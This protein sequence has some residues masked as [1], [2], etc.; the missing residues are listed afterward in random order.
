MIRQ[1]V[2]ILKTSSQKMVSCKAVRLL[3]ISFVVLVVVVCSGAFAA[4]R[5]ES[6]EPGATIITYSDA[7][8]WAINMAS[9]GD[10]NMTPVTTAGRVVG[11]VIILTGYVAFSV[12]IGVV[13]NIFRKEVSGVR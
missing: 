9:V 4:L 2:D 13:A 11:V 12:L 10:S 8:W 6:F 3:L 5:A 7:L 1:M